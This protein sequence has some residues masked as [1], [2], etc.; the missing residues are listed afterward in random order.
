MVCTVF[1]INHHSFCY[2]CQQWQPK[3]VVFQ[4]LSTSLSTLLVAIHASIQR[5]ILYHLGIGRLLYMNGLLGPAIYIT[6]VFC[7]KIEFTSFRTVTFSVLLSCLATLC[8][9]R[10]V[11]TLN[12]SLTYLAPQEH[13]EW[14][15][16][17]MAWMSYFRALHP[18]RTRGLKPSLFCIN[19]DYF[20]GIT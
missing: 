16:W 11:N 20:N 18:S 2:R 7:V 13:Y 14:L 3:Y 8:T 10:F 5:I 12:V 6:F 9:W 1:V 4:Y 19:I 15:F 17:G